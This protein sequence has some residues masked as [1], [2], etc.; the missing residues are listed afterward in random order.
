MTPIEAGIAG[1]ALLFILFLLKPNLNYGVTQ[2]SSRSL[3]TS[4]NSLYLFFWTGMR[5]SR[6]EYCS[7]P[8]GIS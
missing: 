6:I 3:I 4:K 2:V 8:P 1:I 5:N 7:F